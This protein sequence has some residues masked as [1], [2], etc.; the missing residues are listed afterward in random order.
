L[1]LVQAQDQ[2]EYLTV[3]NDNTGEGEVEE[4]GWPVAGVDHGED[5]GGHEDQH[6]DQQGPHDPA[7]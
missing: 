1:D 5:D 6:L 2:G 3:E 4:E 7:R